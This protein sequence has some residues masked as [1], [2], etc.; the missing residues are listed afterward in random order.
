[1]ANAGLCSLW[2]DAPV[3]NAMIAYDDKG[4]VF[5]CKNGKVTDIYFERNEEHVKKETRTAV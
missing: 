1:M 4:L 3:K 5:T 2:N